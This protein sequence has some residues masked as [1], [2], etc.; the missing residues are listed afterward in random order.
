MIRPAEAAQLAAL[1]ICDPFFTRILSLFES[2]GAGYDFTGFWVQETDGAP[3][4][5]VSRFEDKFS[6]YLTDDSDLE[7]VAAFLRFQRAGSVMFD[8]RYDLDIYA[9]SDINGKV[10]V[11]RGENYISNLELYTPD[12]KALYGLLKSCESAIFRVPPMLSFL[13]DVTHRMNTEK[14]TVLAA[15]E[16]IPVSAVM[17]VSETQD[18]AILGAVATHPDHRRRGL[19]RELVRTL[20]SRITREGRAA[21]VFS[22]SEA[23]TRFYENS[24]FEIVAGFKELFLS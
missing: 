1:R 22:A 10:L 21:F 14:C 2:Y 5:A 8:A 7:E 18:A 17:T 15:G 16:D 6:L 23:N 19:S 13:S 4:S 3:T 24:G 9:G 11:Y 20:A 12:L